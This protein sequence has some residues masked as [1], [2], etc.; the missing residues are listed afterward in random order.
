[1]GCRDPKFQM[2]TSYTTLPT[3]SPCR[4]MPPGTT[5]QGFTSSARALKTA[6]SPSSLSLY[7][8]S[9]TS[10]D[11]C[12][13]DRVSWGLTVRSE[14]GFK[15]LQFDEDGV[16]WGGVEGKHFDPGYCVLSSYLPGLCGAGEDN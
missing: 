14:S 12:W 9:G 16:W 4:S 3:V 8:R 1:M 5:G 2:G 11:T 13:A 6:G 7:L 10:Q 15:L